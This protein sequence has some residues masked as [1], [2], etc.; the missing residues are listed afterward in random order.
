MAQS[1]D[2]SISNQSGA[3]FRSELNTILAAIVS[4]NSGS[5]GAKQEQMASIAVLSHRQHSA[6]LQGSQ[7]KVTMGGS[8][9][10]EVIVW[11]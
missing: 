9:N 7:C 3:N 5:T 10:A 11:S 1:T 6:C 4:H 8:I 2:Y